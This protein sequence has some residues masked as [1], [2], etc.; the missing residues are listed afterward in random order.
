[1]AAPRLKSEPQDAIQLD[2]IPRDHDPI[3]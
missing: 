3:K 1:M 2:R